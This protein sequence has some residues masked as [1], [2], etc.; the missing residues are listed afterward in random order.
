M[1]PDTTRRSALASCSLPGESTHSATRQLPSLGKPIKLTHIQHS[2]MIGSAR[3][4]D[5][6]RR[7]TQS[8]HKQ[9]EPGTKDIVDRTCHHSNESVQNICKII[10]SRQPAGRVSYLHSTELAFYKERSASNQSLIERL[11]SLVSDSL[12]SNEGKTGELAR[13]QKR[14]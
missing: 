14:M 3:R 7:H 5:P 12:I 2:L 11:D 1:A 8:P 10:I 9:R 4:I 6:I 13:Y